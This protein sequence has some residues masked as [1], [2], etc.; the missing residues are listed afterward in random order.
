MR[1]ST[2]LVFAVCGTLLLIL[3]FIAG[4]TLYIK[5]YNQ[6]FAD[7]A[8]STVPAVAHDH[9]KT[10]PNCPR[11]PTPGRSASSYRAARRLYL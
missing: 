1:K 10:T 2:A 9:A 8:G 5:F 11:S 6:S 4:R 7:I 3:L